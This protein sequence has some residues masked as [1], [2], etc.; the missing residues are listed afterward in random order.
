MEHEAFVERVLK[1]L[2]S[3]KPSSF[4]FESWDHAG[5]P[6]KEGFGLCPIQGVDP[7]A[8]IEAVMDVDH[9]EGNIDHVA[10]CRSIEDDRF[11]EDAVRFYQRLDLPMLGSIHMELVL[12][13]L[14]TREGYRVAAWDLLEDETND[15]SAK[16]AFRS[17]YNHGAWFAADGVVGYALGSAPKKG[18][19]G[20]LKWMALTKGADAAASRV[21]KANIEGMAAWAKRR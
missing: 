16:K 6:T 10:E 2:P 13:D 19:V 1:R 8:L 17:E 3:S 14:G 5:R 20:R 15:L 7:D 4:T 18:D 11:G 21:V 9:Y 12:K